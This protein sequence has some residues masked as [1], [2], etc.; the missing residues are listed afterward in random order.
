MEDYEEKRFQEFRN[1]CI[2]FTKNREKAVIEKWLEKIG[3][4]E[5]V[6]YACSL[7]D[8]EMTI[9]TTRPGVLIGKAGNSV[10]EFKAMLTEEFCGIWNV[11]FVEIR[12][13][14]VNIK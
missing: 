7:S 4:T 2:I 11:K 14:F 1:E 13:D 5:P 9:Y 3:Y 8:R 6:G 12:G 10:K